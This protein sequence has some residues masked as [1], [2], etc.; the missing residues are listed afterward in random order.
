MLGQGGRIV[1]SGDIVQI[2]EDGD[3][4]VDGVPAERL[5][6]VDFPQ[7]SGLLKYGRNL[8][9][10]TE[11]TRRTRVPADARLHVGAIERSNV[12]PITEL[13]LMMDAARAYETHQRVVQAFDE[14]LSAAV[15]RIARQT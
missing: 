3:V 15:N 6:L 13:V 10:A 14:T 1:T 11:D 8:Y 7:S 4:V 9:G 12:N 5:L 2:S